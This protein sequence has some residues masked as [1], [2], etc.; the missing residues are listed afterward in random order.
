MIS[1]ASRKEMASGAGTKD[2]GGKP[3]LSLFPSEAYI[4]ICRVFTYGANKYSDFNWRQG[5]SWR[6]MYDAAERHLHAWKLGE[7]N[8]PESGL[9][10]LAHAACCIAMLLTWTV[11]GGRYLTHDDR[12]KE[13]K[14]PSPDQAALGSDHQQLGT[15]FQ[16]VAQPGLGLLAWLT[17]LTL[18]GALGK[19]IVARHH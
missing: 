17:L 11:V 5:M 19:W 10:H 4:L 3:R 1:E 18:G 14:T 8:D 13:P 16:L 12:W 15:E 2:D 7:E 9:P 6:R